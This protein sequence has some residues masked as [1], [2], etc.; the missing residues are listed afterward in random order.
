[1][2][3]PLVEQYV[4]EL[5]DFLMSDDMSR[6]IGSTT[7]HKRTTRRRE[8]QVIFPYFGKQ[9]ILLT[10]KQ[11]QFAVFIYELPFAKG[12]NTDLEF[13]EGEYGD[14]HDAYEEEVTYING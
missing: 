7:V 5:F 4:R 11:G 10:R 6:K 14:E 9:R 3:D 1:M 2:N 13:A 8:Q 12:L